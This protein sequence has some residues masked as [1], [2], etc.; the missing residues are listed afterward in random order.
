MN[1]FKSSRFVTRSL[2]GALGLSAI[3]LFGVIDPAAAEPDCGPGVGWVN[4]CEAGTDRFSNSWINIH[5]WWDIP[6]L[7]GIVGDLPDDFP[8][9]D[10]IMFKGPVLVEREAG[11]NN[12]IETTLSHTLSGNHDFLG[13]LTLETTGTGKI[14]EIEPGLADSFFDVEF[15]LNDMFGGSTTIKADRLLTGVSPDDPSLPPGVFPN[16]PNNICDSTNSVDAVIIYCNME[17]D[18]S[19]LFYLGADGLLGTADD[20]LVGTI[21]REEHIIHDPI[22]EPSMVLASI[23]G[24]GAMLGLKRKKESD[25]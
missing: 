13:P 16:P 12:M 20:V 10:W 11:N 23:F 18:P 7:E 2:I 17:N 25:S 24:L 21:H 4:N 22:P 9:E 5:L 3:A 14:T 15:K 19:D 1:I 6:A 8:M